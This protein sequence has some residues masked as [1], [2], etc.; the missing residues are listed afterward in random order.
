MTVYVERVSYE[1][2][3]LRYAGVVLKLV[4]VHLPTKYWMLF[5]FLCYHVLELEKHIPETSIVLV[6]FAE[7]SIDDRKEVL[8]DTIREQ[9]NAFEMKQKILFP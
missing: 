7:N 9:F 2:T 1:I 5:Q 4:R 6:L 8:N 3:I